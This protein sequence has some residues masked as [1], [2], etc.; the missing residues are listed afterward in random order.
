[1]RPLQLE[2][3][4]EMQT[5]IGTD[6]NYAVELLQKG[7]LVAIPTETVYGLAGNALNEE[8]VLKI[9]NAKN[10]PQFNPLIIHL[11]SVGLLKNYVTH[12]PAK[13]KILADKFL[14]GPLTFLLPKKNI[15]PDLVTAGSDKVAI[16]IP[17][18]PLTRE[19]LGKL[20]FPLAAP[21]A[22][23][24]GYVSPTSAQ[25]VYDG[26]NGKISYILDGG[27]CTVGLESTIIRFDEN[28]NVIVHRVGGVALEEIEKI[29]GEKVKLQTQ[30]HEMPDAPGQ[31]KSHYATHTPLIVGDADSLIKQH[32]ENKIAVISFKNSYNSK[33]I[34]QQYIL[35][36]SGNLDEAAK[37]LFKTLREV[38]TINADIIIAEKFPDERL[39]RA[40]N[41]RLNRAQH[42][43]K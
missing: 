22:N 33:D 8:A 25:H 30:A 42:I 18:H 3:K 19:L 21:S 23:P 4:L 2:D 27:E 43:Y 13:A 16:R 32:L 35:S 26:L 37:N 5:T 28:E 12:I 14:P 1:M 34:I 36:P 38:D 24:F 20:N 39:G 7:E 17:N 9:F 15:I 29:L 6:I 40:I 31:L 11:A 10:R 41:D